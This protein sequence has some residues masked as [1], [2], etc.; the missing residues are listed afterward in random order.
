MRKLLFL[1]ALA[2]CSELP[3]DTHAQWY[4][5]ADVVVPTRSV[6]SDRTFQ[7]NITST[8]TGTPPVTTKQVGSTD[9]L[10]ID[11]GF[12]A[13]GRA[14]L[15]YRSEFVGIEGSVMLTNKWRSADTVFDP[16][17]SL[18][19]PFTP[20][21]STPNATFDNNTFASIA[22][23][24]QLQS[25]ELNL[26]FPIFADVLQ[27]ANFRF[28][29]RA[30]SIDEQFNYSSVNPITTNAFSFD[31]S[32]RLIG[33]QLGVQGNTAVPGGLLGLSCLGGL[34]Y[35]QVDRT[36]VFNGVLSTLNTTEGSLFGEL[37]I[38]YI[39][40]P[41]PNLSIRIGYQA[42]GI[43]NVGLA[44]DDPRLTRDQTNSVLYSMP[45]LGISGSY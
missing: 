31:T 4:G 26:T 38:Q 32:N 41:T 9:L 1:I 13:G 42:L 21:G 27:E 34:A 44:L 15:G 8:T 29:L 24:T 19:S 16:T 5:S 25:G 7:R 39:L 35:N 36:E 17:G 11:L 45:Y 6:P 22:Y 40:M 18:A 10:S 43:G 12:A 30:M 14:T 37:G 20:I 33:P 2:L 28:G 3:S 23:E